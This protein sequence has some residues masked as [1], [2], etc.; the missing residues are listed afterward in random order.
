MSIINTDNLIDKINN[1]H[2]RCG[3]CDGYGYLDKKK[4]IQT[5]N[6]A[7]TI[8]QPAWISVEERLPIE[9]GKYLVI[10]EYSAWERSCR[11]ISIEYYSA[12]FE[13]WFFDGIKLLGVTH[14]MPLPELPKGVE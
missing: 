13:G 10:R 14:W 7:P 4:V 8:E 11:D 2:D 6:E 1:L 12:E 9:S 5:I 3:H